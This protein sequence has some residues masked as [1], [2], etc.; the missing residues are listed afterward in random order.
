MIRAAPIGTPRGE[1]GPNPCN[2]R[3]RDH[4]NRFAQLAR[5]HGSPGLE[6]GGEEK[7]EVPL[8][9]YRAGMPQLESQ[10]RFRWLRESSGP[11][12]HPCTFH[13]GGPAALRLRTRLMPVTAPELP[14]LLIYGWFHLMRIPVYINRSGQY[15]LAAG[16]SRLN[17]RERNPATSTI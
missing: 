7:T 4:A 3:P 16:L 1:V 2:L 6:A 17:R 14:G 9:G 13:D 15:A 5:A 11:C 12:Q 10:E 8:P